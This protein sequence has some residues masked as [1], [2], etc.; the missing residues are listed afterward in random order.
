VQGVTG[1][2]IRALKARGFD[3]LTIDQIIQLRVAGIK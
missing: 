2:Y 3:K 1:K